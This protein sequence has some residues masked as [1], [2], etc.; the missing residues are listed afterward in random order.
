MSSKTA[1]NGVEEM[2]VEAG[3]VVAHP[4]AFESPSKKPE[5]GLPHLLLIQYF[6][7]IQRV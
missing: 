5:I 7:E 2:I 3:S 6:I 1:E 4:E